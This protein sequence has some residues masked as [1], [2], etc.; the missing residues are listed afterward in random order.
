MAVSALPRT[1]A[2][3]PLQTVSIPPAALAVTLVAPTFDL[4]RIVEPGLGLAGPAVVASGAAGAA[5]LVMWLRA[6]RTSW[7]AAASLAALSSFALRLVG[8]EVAPVL[9]LLSILGLG[10]GGA[11]APVAESADGRAAVGTTDLLGRPTV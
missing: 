5:L 3:A 10:V 9:S 11:F 1:R 8:A 4:L 6:P 7:L 2:R